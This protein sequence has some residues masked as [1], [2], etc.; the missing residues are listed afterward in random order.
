MSD[1]LD[2]VL[3]TP[4]EAR[5]RSN[6]NFEHQCIKQLLRGLGM[7]AKAITRL[8]RQVGQF[9]CAWFAAE[10]PQFEVQ[11][12][13]CRV[14]EYSLQDLFERPAASPVMK[15]FIE[16]FGKGD[17]EVPAALMF[18]AAGWTKLVMARDLNWFSEQH[19]YLNLCVYGVR[20]CVCPLE[21]FI[22]AY[23]RRI[24]ETSPV[25]A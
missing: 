22:S 4:E 16:H 25:Q 11:L 19:N 5:Q 2:L 9:S 20:Y 15:T 21:E 24:L 7:A 1:L 18:K 6:E 10:Y 12:V 14:R 17:L 13:A 8:E 23:P 3:G